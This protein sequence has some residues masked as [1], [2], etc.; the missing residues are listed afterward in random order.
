MTTLPCAR[1]AVEVRRAVRRLRDLARPPRPAKP[2]D[3]V[4]VLLD[5]RR[6]R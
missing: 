2:T 5:D 6:R 3:S 4:A 1:E